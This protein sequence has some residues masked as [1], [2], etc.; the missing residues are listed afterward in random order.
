M[1]RIKFK[2]IPY[3]TRHRK[4]PMPSASAQQVASIRLS[5]VCP[6]QSDLMILHIFGLPTGIA[7]EMGSG[8]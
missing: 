6:T 2:P 1:D 7:G 5:L 8:L 3:D 4:L